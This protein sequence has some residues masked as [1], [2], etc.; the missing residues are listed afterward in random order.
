MGALVVVALAKGIEPALL[1]AQGRR[2][3]TGSLALEFP[4]HA[5]VRAV[6]LGMGRPDALMHDAE[7]HPPYVEGGQSVEA[8]GC[9][10]RAVVGANRLGET[11]GLP[12]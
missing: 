7:L 9:E 12:K 2:R 11:I 1:R 8:C 5:F 6:L 4:M 10:R 3:G